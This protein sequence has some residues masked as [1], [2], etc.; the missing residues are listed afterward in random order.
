MM[1]VMFTTY[2]EIMSLQEAMLRILSDLKKGDRFNI[3]IFE[4]SITP[5]NAQMVEMSEDSIR[6]AKEYVNNI[7]SRGGR[8]SYCL[9]MLRTMYYINTLIRH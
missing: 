9:Y 7:Y 1:L 5:Y 8:Y 2:T 3:V 4:S 6:K